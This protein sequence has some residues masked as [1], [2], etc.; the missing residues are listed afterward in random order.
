V[1]F[2]EKS[3]EEPHSK[4]DIDQSVEEAKEDRIELKGLFEVWFYG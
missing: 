3:Q 1:S 4:G 2:N